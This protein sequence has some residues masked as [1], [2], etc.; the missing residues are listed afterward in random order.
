VIRGVKTTI[1]LY[2]RIM[3]DPAFRRGDFNTH[4]IEDRIED[5]IYV[6][7]KNRADIVAAIAAAIAAHTY[8]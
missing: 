8:R 7:G 4:Y 5:L 3:R 6:E 1:P 2:C